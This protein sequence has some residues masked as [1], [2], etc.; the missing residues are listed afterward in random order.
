MDVH[1]I[2]INWI[3]KKCEDTKGVSEA[4]S[5]LYNNRGWT[6]LLRNCRQFLLLPDSF[7]ISIKWLIILISKVLLLSDSS[8]NVVI[9][10]FSTFTIYVVDVENTYDVVFG[11]LYSYLIMFCKTRQ[12]YVVFTGTLYLYDNC[13][14]IAYLG[15]NLYS[16]ITTW[17]ERW[18]QKHHYKQQVLNADF[19]LSYIVCNIL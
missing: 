17:Q 1:V 9:L 10:L 4:V 16:L 14:H 18:D 3:I 5:L 8:T 13:P 19:F 6:Q 12:T 7:I 15:N 11:F 2:C